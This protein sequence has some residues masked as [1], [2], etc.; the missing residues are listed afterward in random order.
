MKD[1][2]RRNKD[3]QLASEQL[4]L[5]IDGTK[6]MTEFDITEDKTFAVVAKSADGMELPENRRNIRARQDEPPQVWFDSPAE[7]L[8]VHTL[9]EVAMRI[10]ASDDFGLSRAGIVFEVNNEEEIPLLTEEFQAAVAELETAESKDKLSPSTRSTLEKI[11]PLEHFE[12]TQ[13]DSVMYYAF[14]EDILPDRPQ[15]TETDLRFVDIRPFLR[16]YRVLPDADGMNMMNRGPALKSLEE[17]IARQR[18]A[19][20]RTIQLARKFERTGQ[21]DLS[22][23]DALLKFEGE[24]AQSTRELAEGLEARGIDETELLYQAESSMLAAA[25]SLSAGSYDTANLQMRDALK[26][27]IEGRNRLQLIFS[28]NPNREQLAALRAFD[29]MQR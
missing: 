27:L 1:I 12:L 18:Y 15:R 4:P 13:Q 23:F 5:V 8:E 21:A 28:K 29:R 16:Q 19:L 9:A 26:Y 11:L 17:L 14:A 7:A 22:A 24:L 2:S 25:D 3:G 10:R 6:L 20:N